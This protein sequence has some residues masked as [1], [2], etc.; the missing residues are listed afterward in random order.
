M[1]IE[2]VVTAMISEYPF[3][4]FQYYVISTDSVYIVMAI[5]NR[6]VSWS[7]VMCILGISDD[8]NW[9]TAHH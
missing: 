1:K 2:G 9:M 4:Y 3:N 8:I 5:C 7:D 6:S